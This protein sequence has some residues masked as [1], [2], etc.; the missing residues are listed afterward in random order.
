[1]P[2]LTL[3]SWLLLIWLLGWLALPLARRVW[4]GEPGG[5]SGGL[6]DAGLAAGRMLLILL[7]TLIACWAGNAG[8]PARWSV[9][10]IVPLG[11]LCL[12][13]ARRDWPALKTTI[14]ARRRALIISDAVFLSIFFLFLMLRGFWPD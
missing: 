2:F 8:L 9:L 1:M 13:L 5:E 3:F 11:A 4:G 10:L 14:S 7:W 6:P 12:W